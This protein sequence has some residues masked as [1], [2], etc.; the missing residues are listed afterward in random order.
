MS[1]YPLTRKVAA[2][3]I[4]ST[5]AGLMVESQRPD[6]ELWRAPVSG[7]IVLGVFGLVSWAQME[8]KGDGNGGE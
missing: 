2:I 8:L 6:G 3:A 5:F 7:A 4:L 1:N